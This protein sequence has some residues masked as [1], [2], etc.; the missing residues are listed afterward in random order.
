MKRILKW[1][2][3]LL[4]IGV[5]LGTALAIQVV[6]FRPFDIRIFYEKIFGNYSPLR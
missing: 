5:L 4:G 2:A 6:F 3:L 1:I